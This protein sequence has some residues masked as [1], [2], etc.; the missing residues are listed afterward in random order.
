MTGWKSSTVR[1]IPEDEL[2]AYLD[3]ALSR[4]QCVEIE[5]HLARC[6][7]CQADRDE[8]AR[9]RDRTTDLLARI[10]PPP[11]IPPAFEVLQTRRLAR[12][13][14]ARRWV[15]GAWAA[16]LL[17]A[18][19]LGWRVDRL[20]RSQPEA[21]PQVLTAKAA[22]VELPDP[23]H[24]PPPR[25]PAPRRRPPAALDTRRLV[26]VQRP[27]AVGDA[28][29][30]FASATE[31][32]PAS[33]DNLGGS[34]PAGAPLQGEL[35]SQPVAAD[36]GLRGLW[37]AIAPDSGVASAPTDIPLVPGLPVIQMRVQPGEGVGD[38]TAVD[39]VLET[40]DL[41]RTLAGPVSRVGPLLDRDTSADTLEPP[42]GTAARTTVTIQQGDRMV[43][44]TGPSQALGSLLS[45]VMVKRRRY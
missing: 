11:I 22:S 23:A 25:S 30:R 10:G 5:R 15:A 18:G 38:V 21:G 26:Q 27:G 12:H 45:R 9:L 41:I 44:V 7:R 24:T 37:R 2:H 40:G 28:T 33:Y 42:P 36:P 13:Q 32:D 4:S 39:Q 35:S 29:V 16:T 14:R 1:H 17:L 31:V 20:R 43:A 8:I 3:Q 19:F 6:P 34:L